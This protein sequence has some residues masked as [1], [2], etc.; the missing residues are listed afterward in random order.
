MHLSD[1]DSQWNVTCITDAQNWEVNVFLV[2]YN[3]V[4][5]ICM[6]GR[7]GGDEAKN[8]WRSFEKGKFIVPS[9]KC[10]NMQNASPF[11]WKGIWKTKASLKTIFFVWTASFRKIL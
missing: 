6:T 9:F 11:P 8:S 7:G 10:L 2:S 5:S 1:G 3:P 4:C